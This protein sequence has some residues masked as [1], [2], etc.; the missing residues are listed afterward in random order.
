MPAPVSEFVLLYGVRTAWAVA[1]AVVAVLLARALRAAT[2]RALQRG[3]A[4]SNAIVL[5]GNIS[6]LAV[7]VVGLLVIIAIYA[8]ENFGPILTSFSIVGL[9]IGLSL[10][11]ILKNFFAG[12][13]IL[14]ERPFRIGDTIEIDGRSGVVEQIAFRTTLL[15]TVDGRQ[16]II[17]NGQLM[18][19]A[20]TNHTAYPVRRAAIWLSLPA[21][22][23]PDDLLP[24]I[25][26]ALRDVKSAAPEPP[27][28]LELRS[29]LDGKAR[30]L[31]SFWAP[32]QASAVPEA[33]AAVRARFPQA[34]VQD[35]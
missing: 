33:M 12:I 19:G 15:R 23:I 4:Q 16:V 11:D 13:Y 5:V 2:M 31:L 26:E 14:V 21:R 35:A 22:E 32:D 10:Q 24:A 27:A 20:V 25:R 6:Q 17:P 8:G 34:E 30:F 1:V 28:A 3:R 9:V 7:L 29:V 18:T